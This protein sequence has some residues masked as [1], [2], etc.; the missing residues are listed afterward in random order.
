[1]VYKVLIVDDS[2]FF[3]A[4]LKEIINEHPELEVVGLAA[5]G[6]EAVEMAQKLRPD[7]ISMDYEMPYMDGV[8]AIKHIL[9][10]RRVPIVMFSSLTY[11]GAK[12]TLDALAAGA[13]DFIPKNFA[14]VSRNSANLK[15]KLHDTLLTF[16]K[17]SQYTNAG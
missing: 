11:E 3:Q 13:V 12:I 14:E 6:Q 8:T 5:N 15:K 17:K 1:V 16:A 9:A 7:I 2:N 4:R 10:E